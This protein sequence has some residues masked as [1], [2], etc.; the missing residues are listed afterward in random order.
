LDILIRK[1]EVSDK[2]ADF[3]CGDPPLND[4]LRR[5]A[6]NNQGHMVGTTYVS[7]YVPSSQVIG[8]YTIAT[9]N[10]PRSAI[11]ERHLKGLPKYQDMPALLLGRFAVHRQ[12]QRKKIGELL[13][14]HCLDMCLHI[15]KLCGARY[16]LT[17]AYESAVSW[18]EKFG[19]AKVHGSSN[20][21]TT[22]M[23][24][25]LAVVRSAIDHKR[26]EKHDT[27]F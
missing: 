23:F 26:K 19:F 2:T 11:P 18:Y 17:D 9:T 21:N 25:D 10:I 6:F 3:D 12:E 27:Q 5:Y 14:A 8:Y 16:L 20:P 24:L 1:L 22:K 13:I 7:V 4:Y 15:G